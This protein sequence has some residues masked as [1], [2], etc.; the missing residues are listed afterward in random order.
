MVRGPFLKRLQ[1]LEETED[2]GGDTE[3][4]GEKRERKQREPNESAEKIREARRG[5][6]RRRDRDRETVEER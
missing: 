5:G 6:E 1:G 4:E 3:K 2:R